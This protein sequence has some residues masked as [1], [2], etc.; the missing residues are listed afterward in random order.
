RSCGVRGELPEPP[1][2]LVPP[3]D[4]AD[5]VGAALTGGVVGEAIAGDDLSGMAHEDTTLTKPSVAPSPECRLIGRRSGGC[6]YQRPRMGRPSSGSP[7]HRAAQPD[8]TWPRCVV[9]GVVRLRLSLVC[10]GERL[11]PKP[12][13]ASPIDMP[14]VA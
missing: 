11:G 2:L 7:Y 6:P 3:G 14:G 5:A 9:A 8:R 4:E 10:E 12:W 1:A 13:P